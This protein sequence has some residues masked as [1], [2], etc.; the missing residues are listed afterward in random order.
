MEV[1]RRAGR[2]RSSAPCATPAPP[3]RTCARAGSTC[4]STSP[5]GH[6][7]ATLLADG[8]RRRP[9]TSAGSSTPPPRSPATSSRST[10]CRSPSSDPAAA[11]A[12]LRELAVADA[13][14]KA[15]VLAS[16]A[17]CTLGAVVAIVEGGGGGAVP[18]L[19]GAMRA[20]AAPDRGRHR[21]PVRSHVTATLRAA[22]PRTTRRRTWRRT[23]RR[24]RRSPPGRARRPGAGPGWRRS[25]RVTSFWSRKSSSNPPPSP[26]RARRPPAPPG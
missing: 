18:M 1:G 9:T 15:E 10:A 2:R 26:S 20:M 23:G 19:A 21:D 7:V 24:R 5:T 11:V 4:G 6:Y 17:G 8:R 3:T 16:A 13:R 22:S 14:A 25:G 12:P